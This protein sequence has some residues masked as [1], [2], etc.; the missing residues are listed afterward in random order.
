MADFVN[1]DPH[2]KGYRFVPRKRVTAVFASPDDL[3]DVERELHDAGFADDEI[4]VFVGREGAEKFDVTGEHHG[5]VVSMLRKL[6][7]ATADEENLY[8]EF[9]EIVREGG[10]AIDVLTGDDDERKRRA[11]RILKDHHAHDVA[12]WGRWVIEQ[13]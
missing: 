2:K 3:P 13:F 8:K 4:E 11:A 12:Y 6:Q 9:D 5:P 10:A 1:P 7:L